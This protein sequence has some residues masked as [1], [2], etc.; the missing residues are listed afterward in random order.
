MLD[1]N[2]KKS[3]NKEVDWDWNKSKSQKKDVDKLSQKWYNKEVS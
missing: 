2:I 1:N 3:Y